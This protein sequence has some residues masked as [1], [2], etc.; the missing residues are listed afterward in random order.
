MLTSVTTGS[1]WPQTTAESL[2]KLA[3]LEVE[4][5]ELTLQTAEF[6][7]TYAGDFRFDLAGPLVDRISDEQLWVNSIHA[8]PL[9]AE[10]AHSTAAR[11]AYLRRCLR[12][13]SELSCRVLVV[14]PY[15]L[16]VSYEQAVTFLTGGPITVWEALLPDLRSALHEAETLGLTVTLENIAVWAH[17]ATGFF[18]TPANVLR[19]LT[20][21]DSPALGLTLDVVHA[22]F[23]HN[24]LPFVD[25]VGDWIVNVHVADLVRPTRRVPPGDGEV[26]WAA[27]LTQLAQ[28][29]RPPQLTLELAQATPADIR[30]SL[31]FL[32]EQQ[33]E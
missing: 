5:I 26:P 11:L 32:E 25:E 29:R 16:F 8:P 10:H 14:H 24:L 4:D 23:A 20:E 21:A 22:Q 1:F 17:D 9:A 7:Q 12:L 18:N 28:L 2:A 31:D 27:L 13:C 15:H 33:P 19:F 6:Y 3:A 30:R